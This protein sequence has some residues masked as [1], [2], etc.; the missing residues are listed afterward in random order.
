M[1][2]FMIRPLHCTPRVRSVRTARTGRSTRWIPVALAVLATLSPAAAEAQTATHRLLVFLNGTSIGTEDST[3]RR[4]A[5]GWTING[6]GRLS[7]PV[8]L[9]TRQM[10]LRYDGDWNP[11]ELTIDA[12]L[13]GSPL[14]L[15]TTFSGTTA[16]SNVTQLGQQ[17]EK[18]DTIAPNTIVLPNLFFASYEALA[19]RLSSLTTADASLRVYV[20]PQ[21][22]IAV[23]VKALDPQTIE[24]PRKA[25]SARRFALTFQNPGGALPAEIWIDSSGRLLRFEVPAQ[26]LA[27]VRDDISSVSARRQNITRAGDEPI[28]IP[29]NGFTLVGTVSKP[30]GEPDAKGRYPALVLVA[31]SGPIDRDETVA[32]IPIFGQ[33]AGELADAGYLVVRYDKRGVGQ[34]GG[35]AETA[36]LYDYADDVLAVVRA[37]KDREGVDDDRIALVGHSEGGWVSLIAADREDDIRALVLIGTPSGSGADL[38]LEQQK[39]LLEHSDL[40]PEERQ[41]RVDLQ[42]RVQAAVLGTGDWTDVPDALRKQADIPWFRSL[43]AFSPDEIIGKLRQ[44]ILIIQGELDRQVAAHHADR[45]GELARARKKVP[46]A[47]TK[48]VKLPGINHLLVPAKT[49]DPSEY[50]TLEPK[51]ITAAVGQAIV[52]WLKALPK[53]N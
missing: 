46:E 41:K 35:R 36:T 37:L 39:Y 48:V 31:G 49:G 53:E 47:A 12:T 17:P 1:L 8:D 45:L 26:G 11:I 52:E 3:L 2:S 27:V 20:A 28:R 42:K 30:A 43:L 15:H 38:V 32:G 23:A 40:S 9:T 25:V 24:T 5:E 33:L 6:T 34:S 21:M 10:T 19:M 7:P 4:T 18:K 22:E 29:A 16:T 44:P 51:E 14:K 50:P 13:K